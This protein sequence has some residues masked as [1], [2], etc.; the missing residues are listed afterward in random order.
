MTCEHAGEIKK[1]Q[2]AKANEIPLTIK[3]IDDNN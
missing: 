2:C 3:M 1:G